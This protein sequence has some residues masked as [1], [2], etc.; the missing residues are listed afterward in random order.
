MA[1][2]RGPRECG[3][4]L[5]PDLNRV[6]K[7]FLKKWFAAVPPELY[8]IN[9]S[10]RV[11]TMSWG[12]Q[13]FYGGRNV[14]GAQGTASDSQVGQDTSFVISDEEALYCNPDLYIQTFNT[15]REPTPA[16]FYL[17]LSTPR[18]G[19]Y[20]TLITSPGHKIFTGTSWDNPYTGPEYVKGMMSNM[21]RQQI[22]R[23]IYAEFV[24]LEGRI[25]PEFDLE[26]PWPYGSI[27]NGGFEQGAPWWLFCDIGSATGAYVVVQRKEPITPDGR[28]VYDGDLWVAVADFC[29]Q[30]DGSAFRAFRTLREQYGVPVSVTAGGDINTRNSGDGHTIVYFAKKVFGDNVRVIPV[31]ESWADKQQQYDCLT[32]AIRDGADHR[33]F[34]VADPR[35][36]AQGK[37]RYYR[38]LDP[39][40][41]R[42]VVQV[43]EQDEWPDKKDRILSH[44]LPKDKNN[45]LQHCRD[46]LLMGA[47]STMRPLNYGFERDRL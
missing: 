35:L 40:S 47:V 17:T 46:A 9:K 14:T 3:L 25:W 2:A 43:M 28:R 18:V 33:R 24:S 20:R 19:P 41:Q 6:R 22:R 37:Q 31:S 13:L 34:A 38:Q 29:P 30:S 11:I 45:M 27:Y 15:I 44:F 7:T 32:A 4:F 26:N 10:D 1:L 8:T 21:S 36:D 39:D 5:E 23:E 16:P 42:G 12:A